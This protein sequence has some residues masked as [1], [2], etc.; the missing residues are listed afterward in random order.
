M[1]LAGDIG[2]T[3]THLAFY[4]ETN[5]V[6]VKEKKFPSK[7]YSS[8]REIVK[9]FLASD[10]KVHVACFGVAGPVQSGVCKATNLPWVIDSNRLV[11]DLGIDH[12]FLLNDLEANAYGMQTLP[13][14]ELFVLNKGSSNAV[15]NQAL[16]S[17]G[18]G[19]GQA[20]LFFDGKKHIPFASEGGHA[21]FAPRDEEEVK[22]L[23]FLQKKYGHVSYERVL[24]GPGLQNIYEFFCLS[25]KESPKIAEEIKQLGAKAITEYA[26]NKSSPICVK[27]MRLF[28]SIYGAECGNS[29]LKIMALGGVFLGGG[30]APK[31][32][33]E[34]KKG[35]FME[36]FLRK[37]RF[38]T[39][40]E[41][42]PVKIVLNEKTALLGAKN[43]AQEKLQ[44]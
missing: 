6:C 33:S 9:E 18:T 37:G 22:L 26:L 14:D 4:D 32:L 28:V 36:A 21:D 38:K 30:I 39:L 35:E 42:I 12:V 20:G 41:K 3:K 24:S 23:Y 25:E 7:E 19:L 13:D 11:K 27:T 31:I 5:D 15:G 44:S 16:I 8:L 2:G 43:Y 17:A 34:I 1:Y 10:D 40:L 29:A